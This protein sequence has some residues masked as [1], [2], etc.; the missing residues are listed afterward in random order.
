M[1]DGKIGFP[2]RPERP[3]LERE[4]V[5]PPGGAHLGGLS[6][7]LDALGQCL[8]SFDDLLDKLFRNVGEAIYQV[9]IC[10]KGFDK[11]SC[12]ELL[13]LRGDVSIQHARSA[14]LVGE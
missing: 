1:S 12:D 3:F 2:F 14:R 6:A 9:D 4:F 10:S 5:T 13:N 8:E 7:S 11:G